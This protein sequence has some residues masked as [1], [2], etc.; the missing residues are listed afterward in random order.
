MCILPFFDVH[1]AGGDSTV[2]W[3]WQQE[4]GKN[5][6]TQQKDVDYSQP[7]VSGL[8]RKRI[9]EFGDTLNGNNQAEEKEEEEEYE[10]KECEEK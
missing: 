4:M 1:C 9:K 3:R 6:G 10:K 5:Q 7:L 2:D 8:L